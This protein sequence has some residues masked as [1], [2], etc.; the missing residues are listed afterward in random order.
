MHITA[1]YGS[2]AAGQVN[3]S[4]ITLINNS[5]KTISAAEEKQHEQQ[6]LQ[7]LMQD[8][9]GL[10]WL[11]QV[12]HQDEHS[13]QIKL[14][15][16]YT[17]LLTTS[18]KEDKEQ[19][20][21]QQTP[22]SAVEMLN[23]KSALVIT[24]APG[25]GKTAFVNFVALCMAGELTQHDT[26]NLSL[27][28]KPLPDEDDEKQNN[29]PRQ[30]WA[31]QALIPL[32]II[33]RDFAS[34][35]H[36]PEPQQTGSA[37]QLSHFINKDLTGKNCAA[38]FEILEQR[39]RDGKV[40]VLLDGLDEVSQA[41][42]R[43]KQLKQCI[44]EF[45]KSYSNNRFLVTARP[46][47]YE[48][49]KWQLR[50][51]TETRLA[52][53]SRGQIC[54]FINRWYQCRDELNPED[55]DSRIE[56]FKTAVLQ[57]NAFYELA[58]RPLL[59]TLMAFLHS[60]RH[61]LP[62]RRADLYERLLELLIEKWGKARFK[63]DDVHA[64]KKIAQ[65]SLA[66]YLQVGVDEIRKSLER[67]AFNAHA[68]QNSKESGTADIAANDLSHELFK[69]ASNKRDINILEL[70]EYLRDRVGILYQR[71]GDDLD[72][73]YSFPH[74]SFQEYLAA[75]YFRRNENALYK[76][77][78]EYQTWQEL[79][80]H[81]ASTDPD[82]W[83][84]VV[85]LTGGIKANKEP[86]PILELLKALLDLWT[87]QE[88]VWGLRLAAQILAE[89]LP[90][91]E[92][93]PG[94]SP[95]KQGICASLPEL[96]RTHKIAASERVAA[97]GY[98]ATLGD[99]RH[100]VLCVDNMEFCL[101]PDGKFYL[102]S[103]NQLLNYAYALAKYPVTVA[104]FAKFV[105]AA[106]GFKPDDERAINGLSNHP[107]RYVSWY[108]A[109]AF[110]DWLS[111]RWRDLLPKGWRVDLASEREWGKAARGG[112][113]Q[114]SETKAFTVMNLAENLNSVFEMKK[115]DLPQRIYPWG[116]EIDNEKLNYNMAI[117]S[118]STVG[119]Y[120]E[121]ASPYACEDMSGNVW[122][123]TRSVFEASYPET[124]EHWLKSEQRENKQSRV[125]R[126]GAFGNDSRFVRCASRDCF[127]PSDRSNLNFGFRVVL[128][129][130]L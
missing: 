34:S 43:R 71:G 91:L 80:S 17:A 18:Q 57:N 101:I 4:N 44:E 106:S 69:L 33:L 73:V 110:C 22:Y 28:T 51:F 25:S 10:E 49:K 102:D 85:I 11:D 16:V 9:A 107:V 129:P 47:A 39:L 66:E 70:H 46:Y 116:D 82:R 122:E 48:Q 104:Q 84:E 96:L 115:N 130:Y 59:L 76:D 20:R 113:Q 114:P 126:G 93:N 123:W 100:E 42:E 121:G 88:S 124:E 90:N 89:N 21:E 86:A 108:E 63:V 1:S 13:T 14:N 7:R 38:Y 15:A 3:N 77:H 6:Y 99:P 81:L 8:C 56:K 60:N 94:F 117:G 119:C 37:L 118:V 120:P 54:L 68:R 58:Q 95:I 29:K 41:G 40:L 78:E 74:R 53:F 105:V 35:N 5:G 36:F 67:L 64:A 79:A 26:C 27:L 23:L 98:L 128:S 50:D 19:I 127:Y 65:Y 72:A 55:R 103:T 83:R 75:A 87:D 32:R 30:N 112:L 24:G 62:E 92:P 111:E 45:Y 97:G 12:Q 125:L 2:I 31:H 61:E 52:N 109:I